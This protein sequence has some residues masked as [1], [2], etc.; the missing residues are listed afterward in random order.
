M[1]NVGDG[2]LEPTPDVVLTRRER[3]A[4]RE[5]ARH[6]PHVAGWFG[7]GLGVC[8]VVLASAWLAVGAGLEA[9]PVR[10]ARTAHNAQPVITRP[11]LVTTT[12]EPAVA[13]PVAPVATVSLPTTTTTTTTAPV[14]DVAATPGTSTTQP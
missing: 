3:R 6:R 14:L 9:P 2:G 11:E 12:T 13:A 1:A 4:A 7:Y 10:I 5:R 8:V